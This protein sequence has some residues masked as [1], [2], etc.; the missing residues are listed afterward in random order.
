MKTIWI[1]SCIVLAATNSVAHGAYYRGGALTPTVTGE[2][3]CKIGTDNN[4][5]RGVS[6]FTV[7]SKIPARFAGNTFT[8]G[9]LNTVR[10][11][12]EQRASDPEHYEIVPVLAECNGAKQMDLAT[13]ESL[14]KGV[15]LVKQ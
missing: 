14:L 13:Y 2:Y 8:V 10:L 9:N 4:S 5:R 6:L 15:T 7:I 3:T 1:F 11:A 12:I